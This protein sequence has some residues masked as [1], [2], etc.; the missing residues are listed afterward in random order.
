MDVNWQQK[1]RTAEH[2]RDRFVQS[3]L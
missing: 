2:S 1:G 3:Q